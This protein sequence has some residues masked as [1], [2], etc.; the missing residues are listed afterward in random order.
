MAIEPT[1]YS[2]KRCSMD[3]HM[4]ELHDLQ[5]HDVAETTIHS[6]LLFLPLLG[7][8]GFSDDQQDTGCYTVIREDWRVLDQNLHFVYPEVGMWPDLEDV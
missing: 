3:Y 2:D 6:C 1:Q 7:A 8:D 4:W 5:L